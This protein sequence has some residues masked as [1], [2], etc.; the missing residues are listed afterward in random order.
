[1]RIARVW[2]NALG[3]AHFLNAT[4]MLVGRAREKGRMPRAWGV[5]LRRDD[6]DHGITL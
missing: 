1:M 6:Q 2:P 5:S 3:V 4:S